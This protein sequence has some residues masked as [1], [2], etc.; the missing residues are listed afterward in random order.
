[1]HNP[2]GDMGMG[3]WV[4]PDGSRIAQNAVTGD[5][6]FWKREYQ[7]VKLYRQGNIKAPLGSYCCRILD[8]YGAN[9]TFCANL[10]GMLFNAYAN[11]NMIFSSYPQ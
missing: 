4:F 2:N 6:F 3:D 10:V 5:G 11:K 9:Q 8:S 7:A 1:M